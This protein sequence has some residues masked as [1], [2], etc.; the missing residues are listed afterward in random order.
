MIESIALAVLS[1]TGLY[2]IILGFLSLLRPSQ[3][4]GF[5]LGF[6][7]SPTKHY[8]ELFARFVVGGSFVVI[9]P[10]L[11]H[12]AA[13]SL[14]GWILLVTTAGLLIIPW[15]WHHTF[16]KLAVPKALR[17]LSLIGI[18]SLVLGGL[19]VSA[20]AIALKPN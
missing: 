16:A 13:F 6:A 18:C 1:V 2:F 10:Q 17:Y 15:K 3:A 4:S 9:S 12:P 5:L 8:A 14:F 19:L 11:F 20:V 7:S